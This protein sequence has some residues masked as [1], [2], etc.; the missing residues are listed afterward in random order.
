MEDIPTNRIA[1]LDFCSGAGE[2]PGVAGMLE[3]VE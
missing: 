2:F 3:M 1:D